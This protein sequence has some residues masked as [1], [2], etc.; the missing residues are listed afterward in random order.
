MNNKENPRLGL[1]GVLMGGI[2]SEREV[3]LKSGRAA[4]EALCSLGYDVKALDLATEDPGEVRRIILQAQ[5]QVAFLAL[6]G[7]FGEDGT[8]QA[9][10]DELGIPYT[11]SGV[12]ASRLAMD[13]VASRQRFSCFGI[14]T[15]MYW[16]VSPGQRIDF[17]KFR[18][19]P[20]VVKPSRCGSSIGVCLVRDPGQ[21]EAA[22]RES[23][24]FDQQVIIEEHIKGIEITVGILQERPLAVIQ[25]FPSRDFFDYQA[26]Y[27]SGLTEY[28]VPARLPKNLYRRAQEMALLAHRALGCRGFSRVDMIL[29]ADSK[30]FVL[31]LNSIPGLT[32]ASLFPKAASACGI[33]FPQLCERLIFAAV[34][35]FPNYSKA[36]SIV[37][38]GASTWELTPL[39]A[40]D[41]TLPD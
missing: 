18:R 16:V 32:S 22:I 33:G 14:P 37:G 26:K 27:Q 10:L 35:D 36:S 34:K 40:E 17:D 23:K 20:L 19:F 15:P 1:I 38:S 4:Y 28:V 24:K 3:S 11:G 9:I 12:L 41:H 30:I 8:L 6:H 5:I 21:L 29:D 39:R 31:E 7:G 25:I 2:S 13:K